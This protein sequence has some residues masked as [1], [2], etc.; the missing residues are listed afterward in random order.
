MK[1]NFNTPAQK[2]A[3]VFIVQIFHKKSKCYVKNVNT[4]D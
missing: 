1:Q 2:W 3:G 4:V